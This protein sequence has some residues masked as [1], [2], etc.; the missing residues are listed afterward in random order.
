MVE[1]ITVEQ[2]RHQEAKHWSEEQLRLRIK[3]LAVELGWLS[4]HTH[5]SR[6]SDPGWP[7]VALVHPG[8]G[9]FMVRELKSMTG[10]VT[11]DQRKWIRGLEAADVNVGV[12]R[13]IDYL[14]ETI[15]HELTH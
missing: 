3:A 13:P 2:Y 10:R 6:R 5:D 9:L 8:R 7:D 11:P 12:W 15:L 1:R 14:N 4:Y